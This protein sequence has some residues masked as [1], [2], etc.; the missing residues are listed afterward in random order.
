MQTLC[1]NLCVASSLQSTQSTPSKALTDYERAEYR[2]CKASFA[3][4]AMLPG[5][6]VQGAAHP[7]RTLD[8]FVCASGNNSSESLDAFQAP[9]DECFKTNNRPGGGGELDRMAVSWAFLAP[10]ARHAAQTYFRVQVLPTHIYKWVEDVSSGQDPDSRVIPLRLKLP[11]GHCQDG[12]LFALISP[13]T[14]I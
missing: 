7:R 2:E 5:R 8:L 14:I 12:S 3:R 4:Y 1:L 9:F 6:K 11:L 10:P 13:T